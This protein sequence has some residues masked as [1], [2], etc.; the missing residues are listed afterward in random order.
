MNFSPPVRFESYSRR[1][2]SQKVDSIDSRL[3]LRYAPKFETKTIKSMG[4]KRKKRYTRPTTDELQNFKVSLGPLTSEYT[5]AELAQ[6]YTEMHQMAR[7]LLDIY[8]FRH[9]L[10]QDSEED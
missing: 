5:E 4:H 2:R 7:L 1:R 9:N 6:L 8:L 10:K 3:S